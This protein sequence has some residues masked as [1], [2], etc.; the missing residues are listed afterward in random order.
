[1]TAVEDGAREFL[2]FFFFIYTHIILVRLEGGAPSAHSYVKERRDV[3]TAFGITSP[4]TNII[5]VYIIYI[6]RHSQKALSKFP[7]QRWRDDCG[8]EFCTTTIHL[9]KYSAKKLRVFNPRSF[10]FI[11][12]FI[13]FFFQTA[14]TI[15]CW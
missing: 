10:L 14:S 5:H 11:F 15:S 6:H 2:V 8:E 12:L 7:S 9:M 4:Y 1:L 3:T 13:Y